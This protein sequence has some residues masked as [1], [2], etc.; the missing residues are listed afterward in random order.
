MSVSKSHPC[1]LSLGLGDLESLCSLLFQKV[2]KGL[3]AETTGAMVDHKCHPKN[4]SYPGESTG[5][6]LVHSSLHLVARK[7]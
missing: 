7:G 1:R 2:P 3:Q 6:S 5:V 4:S